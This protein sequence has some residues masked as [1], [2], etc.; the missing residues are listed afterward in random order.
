M[1]DDEH[2]LLAELASLRQSA[3]RCQA[4]PVRSHHD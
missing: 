1:D 4:S 2:P 3:A